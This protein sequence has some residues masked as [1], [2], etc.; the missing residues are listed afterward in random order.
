MDTKLLASRTSYSSGGWA[1][2]FS[3]GDK[4]ATDTMRVAFQGIESLAEEK[5][6]K[7]PSSDFA[8]LMP[9][10]VVQVAFVWGHETNEY[11]WYYCPGV[12]PE[13]F[14]QVAEG[15]IN[16]IN[17]DRVNGQE[18]RAAVIDWL[19]KAPGSMARLKAIAREMRADTVIDQ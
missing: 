7:F 18:L 17:A 12:T 6:F 13:N 11:R 14:R 8:W 16:S 10:E 1:P 4:L 19:K 5:F 2:S 9:D 3:H 15:I